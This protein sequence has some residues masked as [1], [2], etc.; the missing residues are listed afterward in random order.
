MNRIEEVRQGGGDSDS[1][2]TVVNKM[3]PFVEMNLQEKPESWEQGFGP[4]FPAITLISRLMKTRL[5]DYRVSL[6]DLAIL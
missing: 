6:I 1:A 2:T 4:C 5:F 3:R